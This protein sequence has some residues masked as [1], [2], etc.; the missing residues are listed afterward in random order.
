MERDG[1]RGGNK[2][3]SKNWGWP[4]YHFVA[5]IHFLCV[6]VMGLADYCI[7]TSTL[8]SPKRL[9]GLYLISQEQRVEAWEKYIV[10]PFNFSLFQMVQSTRRSHFGW[11]KFDFEVQCTAAAWRA[12]KGN[13][14][15][16]GGTAEKCGLGKN[17]YFR[18]IVDYRLL[19]HA[20]E[21]FH[22]LHNA[23][24]QPSLC[25]WYDLIHCPHTV[26][27]HP[28]THTHTPQQP[29]K[30]Q[31]DNQLS[32][33]LMSISGWDRTPRQG[34]DQFTPARHR[35][36]SPSS[37]A[38]FERGHTNI[39]DSKRNC[40]CVCQSYVCAPTRNCLLIS[41]QLGWCLFEMLLSENL[42][43]KRERRGSINKSGRKG[44]GEVGMGR[45]EVEGG[46][47]HPKTPKH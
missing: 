8:I 13:P 5:F 18:Y 38:G 7:T 34:P 32:P 16:G 27:P 35:L 42:L 37:P 30:A 46:L 6:C 36:P 23:E 33:L 22:V 14:W 44:R 9:M 19:Q 20:Q 29:W 11:K 2:E 28:Y 17:L 3:S 4:L 47:Q 45:G 26:Y 10:L 1:E 39:F 24:F 25:P 40:V 12:K 41:K 15:L 31:S 43:D 21:V